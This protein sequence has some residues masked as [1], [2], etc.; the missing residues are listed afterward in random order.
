M[1]ATLTTQSTS[2]GVGVPDVAGLTTEAADRALQDA[3]LLL[4]VDPIG[5]TDNVVVSQSPEPGGPLPTDLVVHVQARCYPAPCPVQVPS[6]GKTVY[7]PCTCAA[8]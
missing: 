8:R 4:E 3:G 6:D 5:G 7:D 1:P 2:T